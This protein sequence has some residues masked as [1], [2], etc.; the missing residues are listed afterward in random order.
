M[1]VS[2]LKWST[3]NTIEKTTQTSKYSH[4]SIII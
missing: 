3:K 1:I 4:D 2:Q